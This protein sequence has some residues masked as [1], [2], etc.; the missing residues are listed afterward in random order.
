MVITKYIE[1]QIRFE[2]HNRNGSLLISQKSMP[3]SN[4]SSTDFLCMWHFMPMQLN[5]LQ[6]LTCKVI[7]RILESAMQLEHSK[8]QNTIVLVPYSCQSSIYSHA[9]HVRYGG[10]CSSCS[11]LCIIN[12]NNWWRKKRQGSAICKQWTFGP[13]F[14]YFFLQM[15]INVFTFIFA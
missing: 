15:C 5:V 11:R 14:F 9:S 1:R 10:S 6:Y 3:S 2:S 4:T 13:T 12:N 7:Q 8:I